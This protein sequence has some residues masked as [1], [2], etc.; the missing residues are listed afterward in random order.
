MT[1]ETKLGLAVATSFLSLVGGVLGVKLYRGEGPETTP[2]DATAKETPPKSSEASDQNP[3]K[4]DVPDVA[5]K[6]AERKPMPTSVPGEPASVQAVANPPTPVTSNP[7][8]P[9]VLT[10]DP[11]AVSLASSQ[12]VKPVIVQPVA[13]EPVKKDEAPPA[14]SPIAG[15]PP[16][17]MVPPKGDAAPEPAPT[18]VPPP[19]VMMEPKKD[20]PKK[21]DPKKDELTKDQLKKD[22]APPP[23]APLVTEPKKD[24]AATPT[25]LAPQPIAPLATELK[26][27]DPAPPAPAP[28]TPQPPAPI[29]LEPKKDIPAP[30]APLA[31]PPPVPTALEPKKDDSASPTPT[32]IKFEKTPDSTNITAQPAAVR[33]LPPMPEPPPTST[34]PAPLNPEINKKAEPTV[35]VI[36]ASSP[37]TPTNPPKARDPFV[38]APSRPAAEPKTQ[39]YLEEEHRWQPADSFRG[40]SERYYFS[41]KY[42]AALK[43]YNR[44]YPLAS[45]AMKQSAAVLP[46]GTTVWVPPVRILER[47]YPELI[48]DLTP[49]PGVATATPMS[50]PGS[51]VTPV[52][53]PSSAGPTYTVRGGESLYDI[54]RRTLGNSDQ[55]YLIYRMNPTLS[56][57]P[58]LPIPAGTFLRMPTGAKVGTTDKP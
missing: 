46:P 52:P 43:Q 16:P 33:S 36:P 27:D 58:K 1:R 41:P 56:N 35:T 7:P 55:W 12:P 47:D 30:P 15:Q 39:S 44:D 19:P 21:D 20:E 42:E 45:K 49:A 28:L 50:R 17:A 57:D 10:P 14:P 24:D 37:G 13:A 11:D 26:K 3:Q 34:P 25:P 23:P 40:V 22:D 8:H 32:A 51:L 18:I 4:N 5:K 29:A 6:D 38:T 48:T 53:P 31:P 54:A 9:T 2:P